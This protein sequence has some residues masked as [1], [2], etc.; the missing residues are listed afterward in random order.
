M[1]FLTEYPYNDTYFDN[2]TGALNSTSC[3]AK[4]QYNYYAMLLTL[5]IFVIVFGNVLVCM[6]VSREKALQTTTNYLIVSLAVADLLVATLVMPWVVYLEVKRKGETHLASLPCRLPMS[7]SLRISLLNMRRWDTQ[8]PNI[9]QHP[10]VAHLRDA[11]K[12]LVIGPCLMGHRFYAGG[13]TLQMCFALQDFSTGWQQLEV[14]I[15]MGCA[16]SPILFVSAFEAVRNAN[17][18]VLTGRKW[19][20]QTEV[21]QAVSRLQ[22]QE[23]VRVQAGKAGLEW[24]EAPRFWSKA[25]HKE[26]KEM[27][28]AEVTRRWGVEHESRSRQAAPFPGRDYCYISPPQHSGVV[29]QGKIRAPH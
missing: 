20:T 27:V 3:E 22:H 1:D 10:W 28:V 8:T 14:G 21:D 25:N 4:H 29:Y 18:K 26:R 12:L 19:N 5:L 15:A 24:A 6:A 9:T 2:G 16:I 17:P 11:T 7:I 23:I 13:L